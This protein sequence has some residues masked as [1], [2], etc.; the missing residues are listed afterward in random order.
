MPRTAWFGAA[1][2]GSHIGLLRPEQKAAYRS[3]RSLH[4]FWQE[5]GDWG[6]TI[7]TSVC[8]PLRTAK[9]TYDWASDL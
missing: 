4:Q 7:K 3:T 5:S 8:S 9:S 2:R 6:D 1:A